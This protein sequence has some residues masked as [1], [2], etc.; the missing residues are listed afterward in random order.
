MENLR[1]IAQLCV[2]ELKRWNG[3]VD[4]C[5]KEYAAEYGVKSFDLIT[6]V[7]ELLENPNRNKFSVLFFLDHPH[8]IYE[9]VEAPDAD[10]AIEAALK[11]HDW[12]EGDPYQIELVIEGHH[13][14]RRGA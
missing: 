10:A 14:D 3:T 5:V 11:A 4:A 7:D 9:L 8:S 2:N 6:A 12:Q 13:M 1:E